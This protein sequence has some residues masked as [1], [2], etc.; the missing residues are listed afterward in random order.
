[1]PFVCLVEHGWKIYISIACTDAHR[2]VSR[3]ATSGY[4]EHGACVMAATAPQAYMPSPL[5]SRW[6]NAVWRVT[7]VCCQHSPHCA[8]CAFHSC[9]VRAY[10][11]GEMPQPS[12][13]AHWSHAA[14]H[15]LQA[16]SNDICFNR[17]LMCNCMHTSARRIMAAFASLPLLLLTAHIGVRQ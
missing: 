10:F 6:H 2:A 3:A 11:L 13:S 8:R 17:Q 15:S 1:M 14:S 9:Q 4:M 12:S 5:R 16:M 7:C